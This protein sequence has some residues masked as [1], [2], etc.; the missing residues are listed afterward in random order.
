MS[1]INKP[2]TF[3]PNTSISSSQVNSNFDTL[4]ND[5]NGSISAANLASNSVTTAKIADANVT[6]AKIADSNV[7]TA[8]LADANVTTAKIADGAVTTAKLDSTREEYITFTPGGNIDN[9]TT[10]MDDW[11]T[12]IS[13]LTIPSYATKAI[14]SWQCIGVYHVTSAQNATTRIQIGGA[15]N[16]ATYSIIN[17]SAGL[18]DRRNFSATDEITLTGTGSRTLRIQLTRSTSSGAIRAD[19][20]TKFTFWVQYR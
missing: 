20:T 8:K 6:T 18:N 13:N 10:A 1:I 2:N 7:T 3:S 5:Y 16:G 14:I 4:Y 9:S 12:G 15:D 11:I 17:A 19:S